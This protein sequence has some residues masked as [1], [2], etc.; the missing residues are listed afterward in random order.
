MD[1]R[2]RTEPSTCPQIQCHVKC[3]RCNL[4]TVIP[5]CERCFSNSSPMGANSWDFFRLEAKSLL[6]SDPRCPRDIC[7][8]FLALLDISGS[9][10][11]S[12]CRGLLS[13]GLFKVESAHGHLDQPSM[14]QEVTLRSL[15]IHG[16]ALAVCCGNVVLSCKD[17]SSFCILKHCLRRSEF[18]TLIITCFLSFC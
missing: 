12:P 1:R 17:S 7:F 4:F 18:E 15:G 2:C 5:F 11:E 13:F 9:Y 16:A 10:P 3:N 8:Y 6:H 14:L